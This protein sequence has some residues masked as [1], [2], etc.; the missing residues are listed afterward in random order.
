MVSD[1]GKHLMPSQSINEEISQES[2]KVS[3]N[4]S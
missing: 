4:G 2:K 3:L 1:E